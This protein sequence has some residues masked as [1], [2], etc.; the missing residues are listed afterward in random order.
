[1]S[2]DTFND[3][4]SSGKGFI[5]INDV[6]RGSKIHSVTCRWVSPRNF[7]KKII[8]NQSNHGTY[9]WSDSFITLLHSFNGVPCRNC[10]IRVYQEQTRKA[11]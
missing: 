3:I 7:Q 11:E 6:S 9:Y 4:K 8:E 2:F 10:T 1:M 5:C